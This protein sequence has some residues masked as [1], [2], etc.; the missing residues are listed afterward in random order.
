[1]MQMRYLENGLMVVNH[2]FNDL[3]DVF[4]LLGAF[5]ALY[6]ELLLSGLRLV[7]DVRAEQR[8]Q[9]VRVHLVSR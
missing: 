2:G 7:E 1:M 5:H 4:T 3:D 6:G 9:V 8:R